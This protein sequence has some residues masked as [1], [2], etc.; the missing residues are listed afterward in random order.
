MTEAEPSDPKQ[1]QLKADESWEKPTDPDLI[2]LQMTMRAE[3]DKY[4]PKGDMATIGYMNLET[5]DVMTI[6][7]NTD[8]RA[9]SA[10]KLLICMYIAEMIEEGKFQLDDKIKYN[11]A[12]DWDGD[13]GEVSIGPDGAQYTVKEI[14]RNILVYSD[15]GA[16]SAIC[17]RWDQISPNRKFEKDIDQR[18][19]THY[20]NGHNL[21]P[22]EVIPILKRLYDGRNTTYD[23]IF[24]EYL[25]YAGNNY[26]AN[27]EIW[28]Y[29]FAHKTGT[30]FGNINDFGVVLS[31]HPYAY[32][33]MTTGE[34]PGQIE[35]VSR[36]SKRMFQ[37][38]VKLTEGWVPEY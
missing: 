24:N 27:E 20:E 18:Y 13:I 35:V 4:F 22:N 25:S 17:R 31:K 34:I 33:F 21:N 2:D 7:G 15:N 10:A 5:G 1:I 3:I 23:L 30:A 16:T 36:M 9:A 26:I 29:R 8:I 28:T 11:A 19:Q 32:V 12:L 37:W 6:N 38:H 14:L